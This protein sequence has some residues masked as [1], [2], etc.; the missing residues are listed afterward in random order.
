MAMDHGPQGPRGSYPESQYPDV[1]LDGRP[2]SPALA[3]LVGAGVAAL[4]GVG[5][6]RV[7]R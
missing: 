4:A 2:G 3:A 1:S 7:F 5:A 6:A